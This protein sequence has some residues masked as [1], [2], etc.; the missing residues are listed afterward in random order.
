MTGGRRRQARGLVGGW[1]GLCLMAVVGLSGCDFAPSAGSPAAE[2]PLGLVPVIERP[3]Q[4]V[5][6]I[7]TY[8]PSESETVALEN[9]YVNLINACLRDH[10]LAGGAVV[11]DDPSVVPINAH[12]DAL[13]RVMLTTLYGDFDPVGAPQFGYDL[14]D[15]LSHP[16][17]QTAYQGY[18]PADAVI[19]DACMAAVSS[20]DPTGGALVMGLITQQQLPDGGPQINPGDSR[21][22]A[23]YADWSACMAG[24]GFTYTDPRS[25]YVDDQWVKDADAGLGVTPQ[26][27]ATAVADMDCKISTNL[28]GIATAV[29]SAYDQVYIDSH[30]DQLDQWRRQIADWL[31]GDV[32]VPDIE[33]FMAPT[34]AASTTGP[35]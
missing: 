29:Q 16:P 26:Q 1:L 13:A 28:V 6:P 30:R 18:S 27:I 9:Q 24:K 17:N 14:G 10:G 5:R 23:A 2:P 21:M 22:V 7:D 12:V 31:A 8:F 20:V 35:Q 11:R 34:P 25:A 3:D 19:G 32:Q 33:G 4:V 15:S